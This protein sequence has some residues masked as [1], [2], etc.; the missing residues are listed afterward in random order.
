MIKLIKKVDNE[1]VYW[2]AWKD[3]KTVI[4]HFGVVGDIGGTEE[5]K[6]KLFEKAKKVIGILA[7][8]KLDEG[9][10][11]LD[12][13]EL[14]EL[15]VQYRYEENQMDEAHERRQ[16]VEELM[17]DC[18]GRT[19]NGSSDGGDI[20]S[21][22]NNVFN[23]VI[24]VQRALKTTLEELSNNQ[25]LDHVKIAFLDEDEE[26]VSLYPKDTNFDIT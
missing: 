26:Y 12:E 17:N 23:Y 22:S 5:V 18:L 16:L 13:E 1:L 9:Y 2:K 7:E 19:G 15:V 24:D 11:H 6:L 20:G 14:I 3:G 25:L 21:G 4:V 10:E 8:E